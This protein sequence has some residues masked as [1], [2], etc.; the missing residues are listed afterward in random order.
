MKHV[1]NLTKHMPVKGQILPEGHPGLLD[2]VK[3]F[4]ENP[5]GVIEQH[6]QKAC[7]E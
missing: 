7:P 5:M 4:V 3:G 6:L 1:E 2:S